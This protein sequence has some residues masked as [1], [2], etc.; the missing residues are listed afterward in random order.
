MKRL[1]S[2]ILASVMAFGLVACGTP[3]SSSQEEGTPEASSPAAEDSTEA[4]SEETDPATEEGTESLSEDDTQGGAEEGSLEAMFEQ[5]YAQTE[6]VSQIAL[7]SQN[8]DLSDAESVEYLLGLTS[9]DD[10]ETAV[11]SEAMINAI[12]YSAA[13]VQVKEGADMD[14]IA[15]E[16]REGVNPAKWVCVIADTVI[17]ATYD[18]YILMVMSSQ[19]NA[20][21]VYEAFKSVY[22]EGVSEAVSRS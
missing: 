9:T 10:I 1:I 18:N 19:E 4:S 13:L 5:I 2:L 16:I 7:M 8:V 3:S 11:I 22:G 14:A 12:A 21:E 17:T 15:T 20:T 6:N